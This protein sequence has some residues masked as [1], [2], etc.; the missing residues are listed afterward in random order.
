MWKSL[1]ILI[2][3]VVA[4]AGAVDGARYGICVIGVDSP[5]N[6]KQYW[7]HPDRYPGTPSRPS[8]LPAP[9]HC[10]DVT[11]GAQGSYGPCVVG[12]DSPCNGKRWRGSENSHTIRF[13]PKLLAHGDLDI[14][15]VE[16]PIVS[17]DP[18]P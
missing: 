17:P 7:K 14:A 8:K 5:C 3:V 9:H 15:E 6:A 16:A 13:P 2:A 12:R 10:H 18:Q 11:H 4:L 1:T